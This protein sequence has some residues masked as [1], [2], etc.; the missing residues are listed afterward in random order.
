MTF[1]CT[2]DQFEQIARGFLGEPNRALS[3]KHELRFGTHGSI[4]IDL[5]KCAWFDHEAG[6]G[7]DEFGFVK[8]QIG[9]SD[10]DTFQ[11]LEQRGFKN[12]NGRS[13]A[14][15]IKYD[16]AQDPFKGATFKKNDKQ[17]RVV[18]TW[19]YKDETG[20]EL[21]EVCRLENG[22]TADGKPLKTYR[23][24]RR[25]LAAPGQYI[26][27]VK[28]VRQVPYRLPELIRAVEQGEIIFCRRRREMRG[29]GYRAWRCRDLQ[30]HGRRQV[31]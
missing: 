29:R 23:Q 8:A 27:D 21:F 10:R 1:Q 6:Q 19:T 12:G 31:A 14:S 22:E 26:N 25:D 24:R 4:S 7:G 16:P 15:A 11:R 3:T 30:R 5:K 13:N 18:K 20:T 28:G 17:F 9:G 2:P